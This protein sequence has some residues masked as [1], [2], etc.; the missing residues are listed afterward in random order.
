MTTKPESLEVQGLEVEIRRKD[1]SNLHLGVYPP[2]GKV[3]VSAP[4]AVSDEAIRLAIISKWSWIKRKIE[5]FTNQS[6]LP[7]RE[8]VSG[9]SHYIFGHRHLLRVV[10][11]AGRQGVRLLNK[12]TI[13]LSVHHDSTPEHIQMV[14]ERWQRARLREALDPLVTHWQER[15]G[16]KVQFWGIKRMKTK[17]GSC[18]SS[19]QRIWFNSELAKKPIECIELL[20]VHELLHLYAPDHGDVFI[21]MMDEHL[22]DWNSRQRTLNSLPLSF[23]RWNC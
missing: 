18:V 17:W 20:V 4:L 14:L 11:S 1:I 3:R 8:Y 10:M 2:D 22:P 7:R 16:V 12:S 23:D 13:E 5:S 19:S 21:S 6:R 15:I 9:E